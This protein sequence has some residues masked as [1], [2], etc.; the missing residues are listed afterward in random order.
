MQLNRQAVR[1]YDL[2]L[3]II[4]VVAVSIFAIVAVSVTPEHTTKDRVTQLAYLND[5][6]NTLTFEQVL[7]KDASQWT[8]ASSPVNLGMS[9]TAYWFSFI[10]APAA[11]ST[12]D[13]LLEIDYAL[14]DELAVAVYPISSAAPVAR[15]QAGDKQK[16]TVRPIANTT[17]LFSLPVSAAP[18]KVLV[19]VETS[20]TL[21]MPIAVWEE[22]EFI[23]YA[24]SQNLALGLFFGFLCAMAISN[25]FLFFT[26]KN[27]SFLFYSGYSFS[28]G[29][30]LASLHGVGYAYLWPEQVW[31]QGKAV[32]IFGNA[33]VLF[34]VLFSRSLLPI[35]EFSALADKVIKIAAWGFGVGILT[36]MF[37]P[38]SM[39]LKLYLIML[40]IIVIIAMIIGGWLSYK[41]V[42]IARY[43]TVAWLLLLISGLVV[44]LDSVNIIH[45]GISSS[46]LLIIAGTVETVIL[47]L[48]LAINYSHSHDELI[49]TQQFALEQEKEASK[50][51]EAL[52]EVQKRY[53]DDLEYK[54][55]ERTLE[56][57]ITLR[58]LSEV[59][60]ELERLTAV[61]PLTGIN[62]RRHFD[63]K[64]K[65]EGRRSRREQTPLSI[66]VFDVDHFKRIND[67]Y[68]HAGGD[69]CLIHI[70]SIMQSMLHRLSDD[71]S[72]IGGEEFALILPN[73]DSEG[74][75]HVVEA[76]RE[77]IENS[78]IMFE[79]EA[80]HLTISAGL[81]TSVITDEEHAEALLRLADE[82]L[83]AAK[84]SG[85]NKV[86]FK[87]FSG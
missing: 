12:E 80:I 62:N 81:T 5:A 39:A 31:F 42:S 60:Q 82:Q 1:N 56:L 48:I 44:S 32:V 57:E 13:Y 37:L 47:G 86:L 84:E 10:V 14:L 34:A 20:G 55:G 41:R 71:L 64:L 69:A 26:T 77:R 51:Q 87:P 50:A 11:S 6:G 61:D 17:P 83:Y 24:A 85:R 27:R 9:S 58:E 78:P 23:E 15:Y 70:T 66:A 36:S 59:N 54:V 49:T 18:L 45:V 35:A 2:A 65:S 25:I 52:L 22:N 30:T 72:R 40:S 43:F 7:E 67:T 46:Y 76:I 38:Y 63:K 68:G 4:T 79:G 29:L 28:L 21:R 74:A 19:R 53:Q 16:F 3:F 8:P 33:A 75:L 73:T